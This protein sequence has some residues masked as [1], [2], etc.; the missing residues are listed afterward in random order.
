M[1]Q[2]GRLRVRFPMTAF[3]FF[4]AAPWP[5]CSI[6]SVTEVS[7]RNLLRGGG[8]VK[9]GRRVRLT[10]PPPTVSRLSRRS[11]KCGSLRRLTTPWL[12]RPVTGIPLPFF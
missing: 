5:W 12:P 2:A 10:D 7:K 11:R 6:Q 3:D 9:G 1:L 8:G 4:L